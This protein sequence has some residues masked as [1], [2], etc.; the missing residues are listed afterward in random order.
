MGYFNLWRRHF[1]SRGD[2]WNLIVM[3]IQI[4]KINFDLGIFLIRIAIHFAALTL[5]NNSIW[6]N[7]IPTVNVVTTYYMN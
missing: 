6:V 2:F 4:Y 3:D 1:G 7:E 5:N